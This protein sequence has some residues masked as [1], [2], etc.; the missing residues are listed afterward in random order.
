M[1]SCQ[2]QQALTLTA[3]VPV[4]ARAVDFFDA[5]GT[6]FAMANFLNNFIPGAPFAKLLSLP[7]SVL[8]VP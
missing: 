3:C 7:L 6:L 4:A 2:Y 5:S 8:D 1:T